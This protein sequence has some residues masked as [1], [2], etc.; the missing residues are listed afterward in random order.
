MSRRALL[1]ALTLIPASAAAYPT[2]DGA[3]TGIRRLE[4]Q[5]RVDAGKTRGRKLPPG[6]R[7]PSSQVRL[8]MTAEGKDLRL[9]EATPKDAALQAGLEALLK[10]PG[11]H[12]YKVAL[13]DISDPAHPRYAAVRPT[14]GQTPGSVAK[15]LVASALLA[16]VAARFGD[17]LEARARFLRETT[18]AADA[19]L[20]PNGH[21]VP[22]VDGERT[23]IRAVKL[24]DRFTLWEWLDHALSASSN[25]AGTLVWR[26]AIL[27]ALMGDAYP[28]PA[29]D[30]ALFAKWDRPTFTQA[31]FEAVDAPLRGAQ[32]APE[33]FQL[34]T[35]F[36]K[37]ASR[38]LQSK[39]STATPLALVQWMLAVE[40]GRVVDEL[41]SLELKRLMYLTRRRVRY[42][43]SPS[44]EDSGIFFK[45]GSLFQCKPEAGYSCGQ[46]RGN[47]TNVL[48]A[49][50]EVETPA[51][52][53]EARPTVYIVAVMSNELKKNA[54]L[55]HGQLAT[56][57]HALVRG[58]A[59]GA[60][61]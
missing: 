41:S 18:V 27:M 7:W 24:G 2:D 49:L 39:S 6:A 43:M 59:P 55:D 47:K 42:A 32:L 17:D 8:H 37:G 1:L 9:S 48:N 58:A 33:T 30:A 54:A 29:R 12:S 34:R 5:A 50:V 16:Q 38:Y 25:A 19:W 28:P 4:W 46:Y 31:A 14:E 51:G 3:R 26:E 56:D 53:G 13:L 23:A 21:E 11:Y 22:V 15:L 44:L 20:M 10:R 45:S 35:F 36:T 40:Q 61:P 60:S 52:P 57:I